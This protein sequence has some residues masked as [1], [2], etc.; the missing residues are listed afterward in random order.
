MTAFMHVLVNKFYVMRACINKIVSIA[1]LAAGA[2]VNANRGA[3]RMKNTYRRYVGSDI[4]IFAVT[5]ISFH[6]LAVFAALFDLGEQLYIEHQGV[7]SAGW[8]DMRLI[9]ARL[10]VCL[11]LMLFNLLVSLAMVVE[12]T[13]IILELLYFLYVLAS[14]DVMSI[15]L[16]IKKYVVSTCVEFHEM[17]SNP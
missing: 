1:L 8:G 10:Y 14:Y 16:V 2:A 9:L 4:S 5:V 17:V 12:F 6:H 13:A 11:G 15:L 3:E 7:L